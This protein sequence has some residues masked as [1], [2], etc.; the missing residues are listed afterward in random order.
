M[1]VFFFHFKLFPFLIMG[2]QFTYLFILKDGIIFLFPLGGMTH[3]LLFHLPL[4]CLTKLPWGSGE[5]HHLSST[6]SPITPKKLLLE[7]SSHQSLIHPFPPVTI[8]FLSPII[9]FSG[10]YLLCMEFI[11]QPHPPHPGGIHF[12]ELGGD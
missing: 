3:K 11:V 12:L 4:A 10:R 8:L 5:C 9:S 7:T 2:F 6:L 1:F